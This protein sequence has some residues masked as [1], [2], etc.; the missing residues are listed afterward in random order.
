[1][2]LLPN[3]A[4]ANQA[5]AVVSVVEFLADGQV[6]LQ[7]V[8]VYLEQVRTGRSP[9]RLVRKFYYETSPKVMRHARQFARVPEIEAL[10]ERLVQLAT[11]VDRLRIEARQLLCKRQ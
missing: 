11:D 2:N 8:P 3:T 7:A 10:H 1:M 5:A 4:N 6:L 9:H